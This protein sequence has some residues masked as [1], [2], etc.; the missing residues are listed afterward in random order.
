MLPRAVTAYVDHLTRL[1][2]NRHRE[3]ALQV[4]S[5]QE[6]RSFPLKDSIDDVFV[7]PGAAPRAARPSGA[8]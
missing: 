4:N 7:G 6:R 1:G 2:W 5:C 8:S 3:A